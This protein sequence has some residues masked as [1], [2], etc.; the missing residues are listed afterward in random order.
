MVE[1]QT[2]RQYGPQAYAPGDGFV[3]RSPGLAVGAVCGV[4]AVD[5]IAGV[6]YLAFGA[7]LPNP[8]Q[9]AVVVNVFT[10]V[11]GS[12][13]EIGA[14]DLRGVEFTLAYLPSLEIPPLPLPL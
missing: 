3:M 4:S 13:V 8:D 1:V 11:E 6:P 2:F 5:K 14:L 10:I 7:I 12:L 9:N